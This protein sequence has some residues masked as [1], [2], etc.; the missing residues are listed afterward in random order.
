MDVPKAVV[1]GKESD[2]CGR[3]CM[4]DATNSGEV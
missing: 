3:R 2:F 1:N 4:E